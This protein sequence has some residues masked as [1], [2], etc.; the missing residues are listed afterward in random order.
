VL[1]YGNINALC[2][3][4]GLCCLAP[5][6]LAQSV[7]GHAAP[8]GR[9]ISGGY[10]FTVARCGHTVRSRWRDA[11][12]AVVA[13]EQLELGA[14]G[15][16][17]YAYNR[18]TIAET[19]T[20]INTPQGFDITVQRS[21]KV[22]HRLLPP[23]AGVLVG[24]M[25]VSYAEAQLRRLVAGEE[26]NFPVLV[27]DHLSIVDFE[28][29]KARILADGTI[30]LLMR[31]ASLFAR[32]FVDPMHIEIGANGELKG[33]TGRILP[34]AG[35]PGRPAQLDARVVVGRRVAECLPEIS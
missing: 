23:V 7:E 20:V 21:G 28:M 5:L 26:L 12:G 29:R 18:V 31:P 6:T 22:Q 25:V 8:L 17:R 32:L 19:A 3:V 10:S 9:G 30:D 13:T 4:L 27:P 15:F 35:N 14:R 34:A 33:F 11:A 24:P 2:F 16:D 1:S